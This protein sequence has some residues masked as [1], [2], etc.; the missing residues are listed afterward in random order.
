MSLCFITILS[1]TPYLIKS[2][3]RKIFLLFSCVTEFL[4]TTNIN[5]FNDIPVNFVPCVQPPVNEIAMKKLR[6][7]VVPFELSV[8]RILNHELINYFWYPKAI[9]R[10]FFD[11]K[12]SFVNKKNDSNSPQL[13]NDPFCM[14]KQL[15]H[16]VRSS[17]NLENVLDD[18][19]K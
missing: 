15:V 6:P 2:I 14:L 18:H 1:Y 4:S 3:Q 7:I 16:C 10:N 9:G 5:A 17:P 13:S 8:F 12:F 11:S 19:H